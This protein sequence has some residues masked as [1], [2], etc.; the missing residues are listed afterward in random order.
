MGIHRRYLR[1]TELL[2]MPFNKASR[3]LWRVVILGLLHDTGRDYCYRCERRISDPKEISIEH[4]VPWESTQ[5]PELFWD[6]NNVAFSH[7][8]CNRPL[9]HRLKVAV[10]GRR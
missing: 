6:L 2:G 8:K 7:K 4:K 1:R 10:L 9:S 3:D 5:R